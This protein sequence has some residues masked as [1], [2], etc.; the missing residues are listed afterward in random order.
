MDKCVYSSQNYIYP[1]SNDV[2]YSGFIVL[3]SNGIMVSSGIIASSVVIVS[4][5]TFKLASNN[6]L[7]S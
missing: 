3:R 4:M 6:Y 7:S 2:N 1:I 5:L